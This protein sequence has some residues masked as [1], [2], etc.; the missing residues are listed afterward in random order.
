MEQKQ[1]KYQ[2]I[3]LL[4]CVDLAGRHVNFV[5]QMR[6]SISNSLRKRNGKGRIVDLRMAKSEGRCLV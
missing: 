3:N 4:W 6:K 5:L 1:R 2:D